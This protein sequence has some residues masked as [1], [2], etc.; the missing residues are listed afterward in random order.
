[1]IIT[2]DVRDV[3]PTLEDN[4]ID[5]IVTSPPYYQLRDYGMEN[6]IGKEDTYESYINELTN[7]FI[8]CNRVLK[9]TGTLWINLGD[10][11]AGSNNGIGSVDK[12]NPD[13]TDNER[14][15]TDWGNCSISDR[16]LMLLPF[17]LAVSLQK[18]GYIL[19]NDIIW[20]KPN[21]M[22][23]GGKVIN[24]FTNCY[25][26]ILFFTK[27]DTGYFFNH[28]AVMEDAKYDGFKDVVKLGYSTKYS[29]F[30]DT[31]TSSKT[32]DV[33]DETIKQLRK[34]HS[35]KFGGNKYPSNVENNIYS[36]NE[37]HPSGK[38]LKRDMW[39]IPTQ[40]YT[41]AHFA[42]FP[43]KLV[44]TCILAG[45]PENGT[46]LDVFNGSGTT[47]K[48]AYDL[49]RKYIGIELNPEYV[50]LS[51]KRIGKYMQSKLEESLI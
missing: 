37:Y 24:K 7:V 10:K 35:T 8:E 50:K 34:K 30:A 40:P 41:G 15:K 48:V 22:P 11:Y 21:A 33:S 46:V 31:K 18:V 42:C 12:K 43:E 25:E 26:H 5:C 36:G 39:E 2:G 27:I 23:S 9:D 16:N 6:Q 14:L 45:C 17:R 13:L 29:N 20:Y 47:G 49:G 32:L 28:T 4:S 3:L 51:E 38:R 19:R 44:E 1:M